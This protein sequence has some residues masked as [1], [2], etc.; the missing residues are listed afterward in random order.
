MWSD[1]EPIDPSP[2]IDQAV[3]G[4]FPWL[5]IRCARCE[6]ARSEVGERSVEP[7]SFV[8]ACPHRGV[9]EDLG[10]HVDRIAPTRRR[11]CI[12]PSTS[13]ST[14]R[15]SPNAQ[16]PDRTGRKRFA[17]MTSLSGTMC[18]RRRNLLFQV[19][20]RGPKPFLRQAD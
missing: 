18:R 1:G 13:V 8:E 11:P 3:N 14:L 17:T 12:R 4:G 20:N 15:K 9:G 2:T 5:E 19:P 10:R 16:M 6:G 7:E